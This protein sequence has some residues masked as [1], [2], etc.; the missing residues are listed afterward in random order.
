MLDYFDDYDCR[1]TN[2][3][4]DFCIEG[5]LNSFD[6]DLMEDFVILSDNSIFS[7]MDLFE[8]EDDFTNNGLLAR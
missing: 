5:N 8:D 2:V 4:S 1:F 6:R 7:E 3:L